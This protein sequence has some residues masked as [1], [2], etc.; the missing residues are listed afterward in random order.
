MLLD[1]NFGWYDRCEINKVVLSKSIGKYIIKH[2]LVEALQ[3]DQTQ[4][5][6]TREWINKQWYN[7]ATEYY[8]AIRKNTTLLHGNTNKSHNGDRNHHAGHLN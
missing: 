5:T 3:I 2:K 6:L 7:H 4:C 8:L 1:L